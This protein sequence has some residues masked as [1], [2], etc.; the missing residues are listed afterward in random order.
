M[1]VHARVDERLIHGQVA[2]VWTNTVG[3]TRLVVANDEAAT[4]QML[5]AALKISKPAGV[6]LSILSRRRAVERFS[7]GAYDDERVFLIFKT[8]GDAHWCIDHGLT[9]AALNI[10]NVPTRPG[11]RAI[12]ASV[13]L[14]PEEI[15]Q[16]RDLLGRGVR[17]TAQML[18]SE[19]DRSIE[20]YLKE[21]L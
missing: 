1:I 3:A 11:T 13:A 7:E 18:P 12:K 4:D 17:V 19:S 2:M 6:R 21:T 8:V 10:G 5:I 9:L 15:G 16:I 20:E 14:S